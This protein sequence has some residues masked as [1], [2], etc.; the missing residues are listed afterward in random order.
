MT[1]PVMEMAMISAIGAAQKIP[2][3]PPKT[4]TM[5]EKTISSTSLKTDKGAA[6]FAC[7]MDCRKIALTFCTQVKVLKER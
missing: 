4:G 1:M 6:S 3:T 2:V 7:P 5:S